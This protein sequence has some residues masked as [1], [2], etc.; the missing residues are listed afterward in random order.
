ML[1]MFKFYTDGGATGR[2]RLELKIGDLHRAFEISPLTGR[3]IV[4]QEDEG[5]VF[6]P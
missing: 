5:T 1:P 6:I 3:V 2:R 4:V